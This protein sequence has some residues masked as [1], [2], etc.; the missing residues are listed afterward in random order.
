MAAPAVC[1][2]P[3]HET[4]TPAEESARRGAPDWTGVL[5]GLAHGDPVAHVRVSAMIVAL[6]G[7]ARAFDLEPL[8]YDI[9]QEVLTALVRSAH[10]GVVREPR[11]FV[12]Y[13]DAVTRH[14]AWRRRRQLRTERS[15]RSST[16]ASELA[17]PRR[18]DRDPDLRIDLERALAALPQRMRAALQVIYL[19]GNT[20]EDAAEV[21]GLPLGTLKRMQ[22]QGLRRLRERICA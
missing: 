2:D 16:D 4:E 19:E 10:R 7:R 1:T 21:L 13:C 8:W 3:R 22:T 6:L 14:K 17:E 20:Y 15:R 9:C 18:R 11:A 5:E 12:A